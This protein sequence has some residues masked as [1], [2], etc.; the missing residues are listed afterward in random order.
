MRFPKTVFGR[1]VLLLTMLLVFFVGDRVLSYGLGQ[2][3][4]GSKARLARAYTGRFDA[5]VVVL[6][7]SRAIKSFGFKP[8]EE[9]G[10]TCLNLGVNGIRPGMFEALA[11][12]CFDANGVPKRVLIEVSYLKN[13]W[14]DSLASE[15]FPYAHL[16]VQTERILAERLPKR[17]VATQLFNAHRYGGQQF[18]RSVLNYKSGDQELASRKMIS[19]AAI[20]AVQEKDEEEFPHDEETLRQLTYLLDRIEREGGEATLVLAPYLSE[21]SKKIANLDSWVKNIESTTGRSVKNYAHF[22]PS[23][24]HFSDHVHLNRS[25]QQ[26]FTQQLVG[27]LVGG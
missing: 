24:E 10:M 8:F 5:D 3:T 25:G 9:V 17:A 1:T 13:A 11:N 20:E 12:D 14:D 26:T 23:A 6:G 2:V 21:Y 19:P 27:D 7:N 4:A 18:I 15:F 22:L 16:G